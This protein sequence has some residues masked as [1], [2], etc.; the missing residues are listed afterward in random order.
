[1]VHTAFVVLFKPSIVS[2]AVPLWLGCVAPKIRTPNQVRVK[3]KKK[4]KK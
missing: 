2:F 1:M 3:K 4:K